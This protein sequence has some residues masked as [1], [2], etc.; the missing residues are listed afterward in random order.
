[1]IYHILQNNLLGIPGHYHLQAEE[2]AKH[3]DLVIP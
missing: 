3:P 1:M 2:V